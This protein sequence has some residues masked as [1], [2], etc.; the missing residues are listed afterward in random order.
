[1]RQFY[2]YVFG[3]TKF[4]FTDNQVAIYSE[5]RF[6]IIWIWKGQ[7]KANICKSHVSFTG[8]QQLSR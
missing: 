3:S 5:L 7:L 4:D 1:M 8:N 2:N 6:S